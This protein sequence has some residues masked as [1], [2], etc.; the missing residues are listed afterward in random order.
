MLRDERL[1]FCQG[2]FECWT[3]T[4]GVCRA[5]DAGRTIAQA[6]IGSHLAV[7]LTP[8]TFGGYSSQLKKAVDRLIGLISP[9]FALI[10]GETHHE[11]R[12]ERYPAMLVLGHLPEFD[13]E[14]ARV[15]V[16]LAHRNAI[17]LHAPAIEVGFVDPRDPA[18]CAPLVALAVARAMEAA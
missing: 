12:Y 9:F 5:D 1:A 14:Q 8:V 2:C 11:P 13:P 17:N 3:K 7:W 18:V 15:F 16:H 4:P 10:D 6:T